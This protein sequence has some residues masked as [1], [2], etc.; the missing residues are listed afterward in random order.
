MATL[1]EPWAQIGGREGIWVAAYQPPD[2]PL[3]LLTVSLGSGDGL[4]HAVVEFRHSYGSWRSPSPFAT[5]EL[6]QQWAE[7]RAEQ[8]GAAR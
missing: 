2:G 8:I 3:L 7:A 4:F 6:A 1:A 5:L